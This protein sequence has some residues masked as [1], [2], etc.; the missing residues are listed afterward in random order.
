MTRRQTRD[1]R[2]MVA[3]PESTQSSLT[4]KL[5][6]HARSNW[7]AVTGLTVRF[8]GRFV[9]VTGIL[10]DGGEQ[11]LMRLRYHQSAS[12]WGFALYR[13][14][15]DDYHD[16]TLNTGLPIGSPQEALDTAAQLYLEPPSNPRRTNEE[17]H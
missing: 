9:Y 7:P 4:Y 17:H 12:I 3:I 5:K 14:S 13:A 8:H 2:R 10:P 15:H 1:D 16:S 6:A 11:P